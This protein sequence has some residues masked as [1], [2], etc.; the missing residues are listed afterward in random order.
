MITLQ[1]ADIEHDYLT[2]CRFL[3][4]FFTTAESLNILNNHLN[5]L[6]FVRSIN[7]NCFNFIMFNVLF[8]FNAE[9]LLCLTIFNNKVLSNKPFNFDPIHKNLGSFTHSIEFS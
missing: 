5:N 2:I 7:F 8:H 4:N 9:L 1:Y 3:R 6:K